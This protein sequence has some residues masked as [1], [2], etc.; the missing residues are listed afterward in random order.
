MRHSPSHL[1]GRTLALTTL[2]AVL[3]IVLI[4]YI[5]FQ[6][7]FLLIGP[8]IVI[9]EPIPY[10]TNESQITISGI[11]SNITMITL[12]GRSIYTDK[13]GRFTEALTLENGY[14][15]ATIAAVDRFG[16]TTS[17]EHSIVYTPASLVP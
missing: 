5:A 8:R 13:S 16:R 15:I 3:G 6:A 9:T 7:R 11:A 17:V 10:A 4:A 1:T 12:N 14:T 2:T